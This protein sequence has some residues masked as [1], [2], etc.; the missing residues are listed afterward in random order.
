MRFLIVLKVTLNPGRFFRCRKEIFLPKAT[1]LKHL[2]GKKW[3]KNTRFGIKTIKTS[4]SSSSLSY[5]LCF[6]FG[7]MNSTSPS[8][9]GRIKWCFFFKSTSLRK[10]CW[11]GKNY[12][13]Q[14]FPLKWPMIESLQHHFI[15]FFLRWFKQP[16]WPDWKSP[17]CWGHR[18]NLSKRVGLESPSVVVLRTGPGS[19]AGSGAA[20][21]I[22][23]EL[24]GDGRKWPMQITGCVT[25]HKGDL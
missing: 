19:T 18:F 10:W 1:S 22:R 25:H 17:N 23:G 15:P 7:E 8:F 6:L 14:K 2:E 3:K 12:E 20:E 11:Y 21:P 24:N 4:P 9:R 5:I 13:P 16:P